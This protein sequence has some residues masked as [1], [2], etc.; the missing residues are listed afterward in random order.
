MAFDF[1]TVVFFTLLI[2]FCWWKGEKRCLRL[3]K[4]P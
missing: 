1:V 4:D 2:A 3:G